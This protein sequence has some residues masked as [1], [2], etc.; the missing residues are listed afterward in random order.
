MLAWKW[1]HDLLVETIKQVGPHLFLTKFKLF[2]FMPCS[3]ATA[4]AIDNSPQSIPP[5]C[6]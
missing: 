6:F 3:S 4:K 1:N 2:R 5:A